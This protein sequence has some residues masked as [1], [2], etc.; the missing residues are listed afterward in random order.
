MSITVRPFEEH[1][2]QAV[3]DIYTQ[4]APHGMQP[5]L[6]DAPN[7]QR[8]VAVDVQTEKVVGF[9]AVP[10]RERSSLELLV[11]PQWQRQGI[12]RLL[13]ERLAQDL[14]GIHAIAVEPWVREENAPAIAWLQ[15]QGFVPTKQDGPVSLFL[16]EADLS[17]FDTTV[18]EVATQGVVLRTLT[19]ERQEDRDCLVKLHTL[20]NTLN[21]DV[22]GSEDYAEQSLEEFIREQDEPE[23]MPDAYFIA[24][25]GSNYI[26]LSYLRAREADPNCVEPF[27][28]QQLLT[29]VL[30][31]YRRRGIAL[32]L[33]LQTITYAREHGFRRILTNSSNPAMQALNAKLGFRSG[34]WRVYLKTLR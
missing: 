23:A 5:P 4:T 11:S 33:K 16:K 3:F 14:A 17:C 32:A 15:K 1:D 18:A 10:L 2:Y 20:Y 6:A 27:N 24:K 31:E 26:G 13:W 34:P 8:C 12:G 25:Q 21:A 30:P 9:G 28:V 22:P 29:G 7:S 19:H